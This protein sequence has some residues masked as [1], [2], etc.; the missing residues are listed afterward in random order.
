MNI[1]LSH[2]VGAS[3]AEAYLQYTIAGE[4][5]LGVEYDDTM[6]MGLTYGFDL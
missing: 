5:R 1:T 3:G 2:A 6:V 4:D